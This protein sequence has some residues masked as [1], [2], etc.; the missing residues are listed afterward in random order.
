VVELVLLRS[1]TGL[2]VAQTFAPGQLGKCHAQKLI[3]TRERLHFVLTAIPCDAA[4]KARQRKVLCQL[5]KHVFALIHGGIRLGQNPQDDA[6]QGSN[7]HQGKIKNNLY[8]SM[9]YDGFGRK[10]WDTSAKK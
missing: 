6:A 2:N 3:Q 10:R 5:R 9:N 1:Q 4:L 7:R 8:I